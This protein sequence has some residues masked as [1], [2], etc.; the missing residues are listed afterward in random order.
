M[1]QLTQTAER[2]FRAAKYWSQKRW[3]KDL[4]KQYFQDVHD[5]VN[6]IAQN[7]ERYARRGELATP[8]NVQVVGVREHYVVYVPI[9]ENFIIVVAFMRQVRDIPTILET[10]AEHIQKEVQSILKR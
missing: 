5:T 9:K 1:Y 7:P 2:D 10:H 3:G 8:N 4:T 6:N